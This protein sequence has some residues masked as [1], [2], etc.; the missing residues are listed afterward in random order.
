MEQEHRRR[1]VSLWLP[2][3]ATD[4]LTRLLTKS[5]TESRPKAQSEPSPAPVAP[6]AT[7]MAAH[8]GVRIVAVSPA[9]RAGGVFAGQPLADARAA[10]THRGDDDQVQRS[11]DETYDSVAGERWG[12]ETW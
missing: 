6:L 7:V 5:Q 8:G 9:A 4:R 10:G 3:F 1:V 12:R 2:N 11:L